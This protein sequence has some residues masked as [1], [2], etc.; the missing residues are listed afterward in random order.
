M[1][2]GGYFGSKYFAESYFADTYFGTDGEADPNAMS[3]SAAGSST[4]VGTLTFSVADEQKRGGISRKR[5]PVVDIIWP[6]DPRHPNY[7][8]PVQEPA[9]KA[10]PSPTVV[11][12]P[13]VAAR[14]AAEPVQ[15]TQERP[16]YD[17]EIAILLLAA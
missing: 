1:S 16:R 14:Q 4:C 6:D 9:P 12:V 11:R 10:K 13:K 15:I 7:I 17:A 3:G 8:A 5:A 2:S